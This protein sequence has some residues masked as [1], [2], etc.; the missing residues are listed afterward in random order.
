[1]SST[2]KSHWLGRAVNDHLQ[3]WE[4]KCLVACGYQEYLNR[5]PSIPDSLNSLRKNQLIFLIHITQLPAQCLI[6]VC[7]YWL[8]KQMN[9]PSVLGPSFFYLMKS[10]CVCAAID[11]DTVFS[12]CLF[13]SELTWLSTKLPHCL[14]THPSGKGK[15]PVIFF[16]VQVVALH[17]YR[18]LGTYEPSPIAT[19][20]VT[21]S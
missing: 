6:H 14:L 18:T 5:K 9:E 17:T 8:N 1:M 21:L 10:R 12:Q 7:K 3:T 13:T 2:L 15:K 16:M 19:T 4:F 11:D 20:G